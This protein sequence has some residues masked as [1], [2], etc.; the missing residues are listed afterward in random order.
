MLDHEGELTQKEIGQAQT[1]LM[2]ETIQSLE[3][4]KYQIGN[5]AAYQ[6]YRDALQD[7]KEQAEK[8]SQASADLEAYQNNFDFRF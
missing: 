6:A 2:S 1:Y 7:Q 8:D 5:A 4:L 3:D